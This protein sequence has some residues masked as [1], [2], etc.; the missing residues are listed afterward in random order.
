M[1][2]QG[3]NYSWGITCIRL[4]VTPSVFFDDAPFLKDFVRFANASATCSLLL[5]TGIMSRQVGASSP[6]VVETAVIELPL[7]VQEE[8]MPTPFEQSTCLETTARVTLTYTRLSR[9]T[10]RVY[11][12]HNSCRALLFM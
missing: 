6:S 8:C 12:G 2:M 3:Q 7:G 9:C 1:R 4:V 5:D 10:C 11:G